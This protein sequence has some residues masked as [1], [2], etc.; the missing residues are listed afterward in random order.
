[1]NAELSTISAS[2][3]ARLAAGIYCVAAFLWIILSDKLMISVFGRDIASLESVSIGKG[4]AFVLVTASIMYWVL[5]RGLNALGKTLQA[6][7]SSKQLLEAIAECVP[8]GVYAKDTS[9]RYIVC[10]RAASE[11]IGAPPDQIIGAQDAALFTKEFASRIQEEDRAIRRERRS[12]VSEQSYLAEG[13]ELIGRVIRGPILGSE[14]QMLGTYGII[15]DITELRNAVT[16]LGEHKSRLEGIVEERTAALR[17]AEEQFKLIIDSAAEGL[18][19][20]DADG[21]VR[22]ANPAGLSLLGYA[23]S[24]LYGRSIHEAIHHTINDAAQSEPDNCPLLAA[25][26][27][28]TKCELTNHFFWHRNGKAIPVVAALNPIIT[29]NAVSGSVISFFDNTERIRAEEAREA[30]RSAAEELARVKSEFLANM[31]HEIRTPLNGILG[32]AH[33]GFRESIGRGKAGQTFARILDTGKLLLSIINDILD[34]SKIEAGQ[35]RIESSPV[36]VDRVMERAIQTVRELAGQKGLA[37]AACRSEGVPSAFEGDSLRISQ[38]LLNL[39]SNAIK[40]TRAG[41]IQLIVSREEGWIAFEVRDTGIGISPENISRLFKPF[42]QA[43]SSVTRKYGGTGLGLTISKRL[44]ELMDGE[45]LI[46]STVNVGTTA[47]LRLPCVEVDYI[48]ET[49]AIQLNAVGKRLKGLR[50]LAA[51]DNEVNSLV[52]EELL[53]SEGCVVTMVESGCAA[54]KV[55]QEN[56]R[57]FDAILM[58]VQ[59]PEMDGIEATKRIREIAPCIPIIG[60]TAHVMHEE[61]DRCV[62][63]G[64]SSV[65]TKPLDPEVLV[66]H[67]QQQVYRHAQERPF[68]DK[69]EAKNGEQAS[70]IEWKELSVRYA[71]RSQILRRLVSL[72]LK[73][74]ADKAADIRR[75]ADSGSIM[76]ISATAYECKLIAANLSAPRLEIAAIQ[77]ISRAGTN[78]LTAAPLAYS[79]ADGIDEFREELIRYVNGDVR[80]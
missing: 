63:A 27:G 36:S 75:W 60:Q 58:D 43:D 16:A 10:N 39:L 31:S 1:M 37:I 76:E 32:L 64:M 9:G 55:I 73:N 71:G 33:I 50:V 48:D 38:I 72:A 40:F 11:I 53:T 49:A 68:R 51:E 57:N 35:L 21:I 78:P 59:M 6:T 77:V 41:Q 70:I 66:S 18:I 62:A 46:K 65:L 3:T 47:M 74:T 42:E 22:L 67:I 24:E 26:R 79:L 8:A 44:A 20:V 12:I 14:G 52:L 30:A 29:G 17:A 69:E 80:A 5:A 54:L 28:G 2:N 34:F 23:P 45:L 15:Q 25:V 56:A 13:R 19:F 4:F 61:H 7:R